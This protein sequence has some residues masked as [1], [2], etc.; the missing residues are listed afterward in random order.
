MDGPGGKENCPFTIVAASAL[1]ALMISGTGAYILSGF[2]II[3]AVAY[4]LFVL[5]VEFRLN[6]GNCVDGYN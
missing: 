2:G 5:I 1:L 6:S 4:A 3:R